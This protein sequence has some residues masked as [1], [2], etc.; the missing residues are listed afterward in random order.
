MKVTFNFI[1]LPSKPVGYEG[2]KGFNVKN[3]NYPFKL[4]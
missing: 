2:T 1:P 3:N 4:K